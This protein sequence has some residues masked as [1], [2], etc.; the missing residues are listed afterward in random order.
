MPET[1]GSTTIDVGTS[2]NNQLAS[3]IPTFDPATDSVEPWTQ[4]IELLTQVWPEGRL[5]ESF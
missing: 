2:P 3:L 1:A 5:A 4:K